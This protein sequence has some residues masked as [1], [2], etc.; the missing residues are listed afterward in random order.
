MSEVEAQLSG[1]FPEDHVKVIL[2]TYNEPQ[3]LSKK[4]LDAWV[5]C[6]RE[7]SE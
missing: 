2:E 5:Y 1:D 7:S 6:R 4:T 3:A